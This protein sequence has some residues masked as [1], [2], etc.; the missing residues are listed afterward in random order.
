MEIESINIASTEYSKRLE[1]PWSAFFIWLAGTFNI[2]LY[3]IIFMLSGEY[4]TPQLIFIFIVSSSFFI[5]VALISIPGF[6]L[7]IPTIAYS[8]TI[9][10][11]SIIRTIA[12]IGWITDIG[13]QTMGLMALFYIILS[14][15]DRLDI[16][17]SGLDAISSIIIASLLTYSV[18]FIGHNALA[19]A[20]KIISLFV[21]LISM[22]IIFSGFHSL[23]FAR[24][25][26]NVAHAGFYYTLSGL[27]VALIAGAISWSPSASDYTRYIK[28]SYSSRSV[29]FSI[30][31]GG[32]AGNSLLLISGYVLYMNGG[33][34]I[35]QGGIVISRNIATNSII[36]YLVLLCF[37]L[38]LVATNFISSYSST[39]KASVAINKEVNKSYLLVLDG[40]VATGLSSII[41]IN[42]HSYITSIKDFLSLTQLVVVPWAG[43]TAA[44]SAFFIINR[45]S[46]IL[47]LNCSR[48]LKAKSLL[49]S[50][51]FILTFILIACFSKNS[52]WQGYLLPLAR[53]FN[54]AP[55]IGFSF[56]LLL[57]CILLTFLNLWKGGYTKFIG[58]KVQR[59]CGSF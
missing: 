31:F 22:T 50:L 44:N 53:N 17:P 35:T 48:Y 40:I 2:G 41:V 13:W 57:T 43:I 32:A 9:F 54:L 10:T 5:V 37:G 7:G 45:R 8:K 15:I 58:Q 47:A 6:K 4:T 18:P 1:S 51:V 34:S 49:N 21:V 16:I 39:F 12:S 38:S 14:V 42:G 24:H 25:V 30:L 56:S 46:H 20:Q 3:P 55:L 59:I 19:L 36:Y 27:C 52:F 11:N 33:V 29:F 28:A 23:I 26:L